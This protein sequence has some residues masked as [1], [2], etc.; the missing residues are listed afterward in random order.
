[1]SQEIVDM[2]PESPI[3]HRSLGFYYRQLAARGKS[4]RENLK[5]AV[6]LAQK[7][8][9]LDE[10][11]A[12]SHSLLGFVYSRMGQYEKAI[13]AG[14]RS[15]ELAPNGATYHYSFGQTLCFA[16]KI[17]E[18][19]AQ[20]NQGIRLN[21]FP[22]YYYFLNLGICN[23][24]KGQYEKALT[25]FKKA[26]Q[27]SP[28]SIFNNILIAA[29]YA[30]LDRQAEAEAAAQKALEI[31]PNFSIERFTKGWRYMDPAYLK[32]IFDAMHKAGL[33]E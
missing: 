21:P 9:S 19:I 5:K 3:G 18:G 8:L 23:V 16:G 32:L 17:D 7:A 20:L 4:P 2:A 30:L 11:D 6:E 14:E 1:L 31:K 25:E 33:P 27:R 22:A 28:N 13:A 24:Q 15:I 12:Q 10:S 29:N 26:L